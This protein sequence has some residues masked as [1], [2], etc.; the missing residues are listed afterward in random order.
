MGAL[1]EPV[2]EADPGSSD[3]GGFGAIGADYGQP[4]GSQSGFEG[5]QA[6]SGGGR[7]M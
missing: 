7:A 6:G 1:R 3:A 5:F 2:G 4:M